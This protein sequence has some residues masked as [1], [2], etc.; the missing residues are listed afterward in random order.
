MPRRPATLDLP[1]IHAPDG[2]LYPVQASFNWGLQFTI[3]IQPKE[4]EHGPQFLHGLLRPSGIEWSVQSPG[5]TVYTEGHP[6]VQWLSQI[7]TGYM[8]ELPKG[9]IRKLLTRIENSRLCNLEDI[10]RQKEDIARG[11]Q[12]LARLVNTDFRLSRQPALLENLLR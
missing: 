5:H 2:T 6:V 10:D 11:H 7:F 4:E 1:A 12:H 9:D 8:K 3:I